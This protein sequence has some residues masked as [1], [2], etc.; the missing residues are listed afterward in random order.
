[1]KRYLEKYKLVWLGALALILA[2]PQSRAQFEVGTNGTTGVNNIVW[3]D[4]TTIWNAPFGTPAANAPGSNQTGGFATDN[5]IFGNHRNA[6]AGSQAYRVNNRNVGEINNLSVGSTNSTFSKTVVLQV[7][8][9]NGNLQVN[10]TTTLGSLVGGI[11]QSGQLSLNQNNAT[12]TLNLRGPVTTGS[13]QNGNSIVL[14]SANST[15][16]I[17]GDI[18]LGVGTRRIDL[19]LAR[20]TLVLDTSGDGL[21]DTGAQVFALDMLD[22]GDSTANGNNPTFTLG[23]GKT[24]NMRDDIRVARNISNLSPSTTATLNIYGATLSASDDLRIGDVTQNNVAGAKTVGTV[25]LGDAASPGLGGMLA[26]DAINMGFQD[27]PDAIAAVG[28]AQG[29]LNIHDAATANARAVNLGI[30][31]GGQGTINV[32]NGTLTVAERLALGGDGSAGADDGATGTLNVGANGVVNVAVG[33]ASAFHLEVG[34][35]ANGVLSVDGGTVNIG[36]GHLLIGQNSSGGVTNNSRGT[37]TF[38]NGASINVGDTFIGGSNVDGQ[39]SNL[40]MNRGGGDVTHT[41]SGTTLRIEN[42]LLM[43]NAVTTVGQESTNP[44][45]SYTIDNGMLEVGNDFNPRNNQGG[46]NTFTVAGA[47]S[48]VSVGRNF[49]GAQ[50]SFVLAF[51]FQGGS[52]ITDIDIVNQG[53]VGSSVLALLNTAALSTYSGDILL[54]D[55]GGAQ[56]GTFNALPEGTPIAGTAYQITY[57]MAGTTGSN[58]IGLIQAIPEPSSLALVGLAGAMLLGLRRRLGSS[59]TR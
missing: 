33:A 21:T 55:I 1:M 32:N 47:A 16:N 10:G 19:R 12:A 48:T 42:N 59:A 45:S 51:D 22:I 26:V 38:D 24:L 41:G 56:N 17:G 4:T 54:M 11:D 5:V 6:T 7:R 31:G 35:D 37:L 23:V 14:N 57:L 27:A 9:N 29:T 34:R 53:N 30:T 2:A 40:V 50:A 52:A 49:N 13:N 39:N 25:N 3:D 15:L 8:G 58:S 46:I 44:N 18:T 43:Q 28:D 36:R 20:G